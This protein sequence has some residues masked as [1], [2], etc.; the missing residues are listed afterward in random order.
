MLVRKRDAGKSEGVMNCVEEDLTSHEPQGEAA[1]AE[2]GPSHEVPPRHL[3]FLTM[4]KNDLMTNNMDDAYGYSYVHHVK[5]LCDQTSLGATNHHGNLASSKKPRVNYEEEK[6][7]DTSDT[8][9]QA[10]QEN[11]AALQ[12]SASSPQLKMEELKQSDAGQ[13]VQL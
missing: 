4:E 11:A 2:A 3:Y 5:L 13:Y 7:D 6:A 1:N 9:N 10:H 8:C 12:D